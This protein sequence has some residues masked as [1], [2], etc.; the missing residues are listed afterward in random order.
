MT[1]QNSS[2]KTLKSEWTKFLSGFSKP[3]IPWW[4]WLCLV[5]LGV[6]VYYVPRHLIF[7]STVS[8]DSKVFWQK[9]FS[10]SQ[11]QRG[12]YLVFEHK[13]PSWHADKDGEMFMK[14]VACLPG[15]E[16]KVTDALDFYCNENYL[17]RALT[18]DSK[19]RKLEITN[20]RGVLPEGQYFMVGDILK[21]WDSKYYGPIEESSFRLAAVPLF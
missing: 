11:L 2:K 7:T 5:V 1:S 4:G 12:N 16:I 3:Q 8:L 13:A 9:E 17:G 6:G 15:E 18:E 10:S 14:R 21:S 20:F 19:G